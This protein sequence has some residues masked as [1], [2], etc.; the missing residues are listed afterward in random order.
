[1]RS[2][3]RRAVEG[4][5]VP[6]P[7]ARAVC[8][9]R[10]PARRGDGVRHAVLRLRGLADVAR[11]VPA[12]VGPRRS[13]GPRAPAVAPRDLL[14]PR[15]GAAA[16]RRE[17]ALQ[18]ARRADAQC[19]RRGLRGCAATMT[20][21]LNGGPVRPGSNITIRAVRPDDKERIVRAFHALDPGSVY[22]RFF[23]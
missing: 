6:L 16:Q 22:L 4:P 7:D 3:A 5:S 11:L 8:R 14:R 13:E 17:R 20:I 9:D 21:H 2:G 19:P 18:P 1:R 12:D 23:S 10:T 15:Y